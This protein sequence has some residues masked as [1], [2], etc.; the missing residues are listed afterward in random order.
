[1]A[2]GV[3]DLGTLLIKVEPMLGEA[4]DSWAR[5]DRFTHLRMPSAGSFRPCTG[6]V[7]I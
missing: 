7:N 3:T 6:F 5:G 1:M 2:N 4:M